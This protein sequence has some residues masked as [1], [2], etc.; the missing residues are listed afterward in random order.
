MIVQVSN[1]TFAAALIAQQKGHPV[2][3]DT[4]LAKEKVFQELARKYPRQ[5]AGFSLKYANPPGDPFERVEV[6]V[7]ATGIRRV[8]PP[9]TELVDQRLLAVKS[10]VLNAINDNPEAFKRIRYIFGKWMVSHEIVRVIGAGRALLAAAL[11]ANRLA[12]GGATVSILNDR[13]PLPNSRLG[14][15]IIA[16]SASGETKSVLDIMKFALDVNRKREVFRQD[17][18]TVVGF[19]KDT[20]KVFSDLCTTGYFLGIRPEIYDEGVKLRALGDLE[21]YALSE[22]FEVLVVNAGLELGIN[23]RLGHEDLVGS[24]TGPW[25]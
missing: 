4:L 24:A 20:A 15:G 9:I 19:S 25:Y 13:S 7:S 1:V 2:N 10:I 12:H 18:I 21:E 3:E 14:G 17:P 16:L 6:E 11:P 5:V 22:L 23:F 8:L